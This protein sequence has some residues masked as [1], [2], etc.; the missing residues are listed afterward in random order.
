M[1]RDIKKITRVAI[2]VSIVWLVVMVCLAATLWPKP[3]CMGLNE[4]GDFF[5]GA[6][7]P[8]ALFWLVAGYWQQGEE[9]KENTR[10]LNEQKDAISKQ[11]TLLA[12]QRKDSLDAAV[13]Q[14][15]P[16]FRFTRAASKD[17]W[18]CTLTI[19]NLGCE[20]HDVM[21]Q[22][23]DYDICAFQLVKVWQQSE[24]HE[25]MFRDL[26]SG[27]DQGKFYVSLT[28]TNI[29]GDPRVQTYVIKGNKSYL[30][31]RGALN[32]Y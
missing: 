1:T 5:A 27:A 21:L 4:W 8:L 15:E 10:V 2:W 18:H 3:L 29:N 24:M 30:V 25:A 16:K 11:T 22:T 9:L 12:E 7:S 6:F 13:A 28:Y 23:N 17:E 20:V 26:S 14:Y 31:S 32:N 19:M